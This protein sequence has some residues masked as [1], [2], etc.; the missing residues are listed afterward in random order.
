MDRHT[1]SRE[2][3]RVLDSGSEYG[4]GKRAYAVAEAL[5]YAFTWHTSKEG[6]DYW[7]EA[8]RSLLRRAGE[9]NTSPASGSNVTPQ[10]AAGSVINPASLVIRVE[11]LLADIKVTLEAEEKKP[12]ANKKLSRFMTYALHQ[13]GG[14]EELDQRGLLERLKDAS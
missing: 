10:S 6:D 3:R 14:R 12:E 1:L 2:V 7:R 8:Y 13:I 4:D 11:Q 9:N 5:S